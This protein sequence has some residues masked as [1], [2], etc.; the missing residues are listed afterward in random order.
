MALIIVENIF[1]K[2]IQDISIIFGN[3]SLSRGSAE[4]CESPYFADK[5]TSLFTNFAFS[6]THAREVARQETELWNNRKISSKIFG[7]HQQQCHQ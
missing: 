7:L 3:I 5:Q 2:V 6:R 1:L 4:V